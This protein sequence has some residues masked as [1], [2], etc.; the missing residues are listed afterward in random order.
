MQA[1]DNVIIISS[2][3]LYKITENAKFKQQLLLNC[4]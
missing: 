2:F 4:Y 3:L 1:A